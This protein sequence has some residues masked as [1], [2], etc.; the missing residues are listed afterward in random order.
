MNPA[1]GFLAKSL[2]K[3]KKMLGHPEPKVD[4]DQLKKI[5][6][7]RDVVGP[8]EYLSKGTE[9]AM[10]REMHEKEKVSKRDSKMSFS[11]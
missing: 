6:R 1:G 8:I 3:V 9:K 2:G 7:K 10:K 5:V 4:L 11:R